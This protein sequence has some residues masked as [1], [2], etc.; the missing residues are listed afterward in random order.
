M[1]IARL[2]LLM[3]LLHPY[4]RRLTCYDEHSKLLSCEWTDE[5]GWSIAAV[6]NVLI[7][8][9]ELVE[10]NCR[11]S[12]TKGSSPTDDV[13]IYDADSTLTGKERVSLKG[14]CSLIDVLEDQY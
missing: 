5:Y 4:S 3:M 9:H 13:L 2:M 11:W 14:R 8:N 10:P 12:K 7:G 6:T 1:Y